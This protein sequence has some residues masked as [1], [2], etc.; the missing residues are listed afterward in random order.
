MSTD[1][2]IILVMD[3]STL[4]RPSRSIA[5]NFPLVYINHNIPETWCFPKVV[6]WSRDSSTRIHHPPWTHLLLSSGR[7]SP[8][9]ATC[10]S[11]TP[12]CKTSCCSFLHGWHTGSNGWGSL[13]SSLIIYDVLQVQVPSRPQP[14][15]KHSGRSFVFWD[16]SSWPSSGSS[17][18][19][20]WI[21]HRLFWL[22]LKPISAYCTAST[23]LQTSSLHAKPS[24]Y[25]TLPW[26]FPALRCQSRT[27][28]LR[29]ALLWLCMLLFCMKFQSCLLSVCWYRDRQIIW[30]ET[31]TWVWKVCG[32]WL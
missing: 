29:C 28:L 23:F 30:R 31:E 7:F 10:T 27:Y 12:Q 2:F 13:W 17:F 18:C 14:L 16:F 6:A 5:N 21:G 22:E 9:W 8:S 32:Y 26:L 25:F 15:P 20:V 24:Q 11:Q 19:Q 3:P 1:L 4:S